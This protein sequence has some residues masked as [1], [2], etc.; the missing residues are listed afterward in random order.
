MSDQPESLSNSTSEHTIPAPSVLVQ[1]S[2]RGF[3]LIDHDEVVRTWPLVTDRPRSPPAVPFPVHHWDWNAIQS[4]PQIDSTAWV[5]PGVALY[6]RVRVGARSSIWFG[7]V[8]R[9]DQ[10]WVEVGQDSNLQDGSI[11]HVEHGGFPCILGDRVTVGHRAVVHGS[12]VGDGALIGIGALVLSRSL[13][14]E[15]ALIAAGA[16]V[17]EGTS[18]PPSTL[19]AGCP[20]RQIR[21]LTE[22][23][24][25]RL[26]DT[27]R[28]YVNNT[29][30]HKMA[31]THG[32]PFLVHEARTPAELFGEKSENT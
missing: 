2:R 13:V 21:V 4:Q 29:S 9:G 16:V 27:Y 19:W 30:A 1:G 18:I 8:L 25:S 15:G 24:R 12:I 17:L 20:A 5:A 7:C 10:E 26:T 14:G 3:P 28:H 32:I 22:N 11:L 31:E 23:Q 6:G